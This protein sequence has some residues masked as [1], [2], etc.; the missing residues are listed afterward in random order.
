MRSHRRIPVLLLGL[1]ACGGRAVA[2]EPA[3][4]AP[5][6]DL[7]HAFLYQVPVQAP[8]TQSRE[9]PPT[10][11]VSGSASVHVPADVAKVSFAVETRGKEAAAAASE[12]AQT[13]SQ[14][15][16]ALRAA[17]LPGLKIE[18][19]GYSLNPE[20]VAPSPQ[21]NRARVIDGYTAL[22]NI[23]VTVSDVQ[24]AGKVMD[25]AI[26]AGANRVSG[27]S[28][29]ASETADARREALTRAVSEARTQAQAIADALGRE[30]GPPVEIH[31]GAQ[32]PTPRPQG[33]MLM[34]REMATPVEAGDLTVTASVTIR[35]AMGPEKHDR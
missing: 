25:T 28:F 18:T 34:A 32:Q 1:A 7:A 8:Q 29:E 31:G 3:P 30:L 10:I 6:E 2:A 21:G 24:A 11:E 26:G 12:N 23:R 22:N 35:F 14:V 27:L 4:A 19:Y 15:M 9:A 20:Y 13:M 5:S 16:A 17:S 33:V